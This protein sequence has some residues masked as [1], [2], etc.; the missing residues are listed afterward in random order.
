M[1]LTVHYFPLAGRAEVARLLCHTAAKKVDWV[2]KRHDFASWGSELKQKTPFGQLPVLELADGSFLAQSSAI[3]RYLAV[4]TGAEP[5]SALDWARSDEVYAY[6]EDVWQVMVPTMR[7]KDEDEK[8]KARQAA[9]APLKEKLAVLDKHVAKHAGG[10]G[11]W[12]SG[13]DRPSYA[14]YSIFNWL[15]VLRSGWL[16]G[17][18]ADVWADLPALVAF[19]KKV[20]ALPAVKA[21]YELPEN[22]DDIRKKGAAPV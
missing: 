20:L 18:P 22:Q 16:D 8:L 13:L 3:D 4:E 9:V 1:P 15:C 11:K 5:A 12:F 6:M 2:D 7:I 10:E 14:D 17:V 21:W 19:H